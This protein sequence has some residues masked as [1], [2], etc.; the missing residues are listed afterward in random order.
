MKEATLP[1]QNSETPAS[2]AAAESRDALRRR[3][4][5]RNPSPQ[6]IVNAKRVLTVLAITDAAGKPVQGLLNRRNNEVDQF[7]V[8]FE[9]P[10]TKRSLNAARAAGEA[11]V[12]DAIDIRV[13]E[14]AVQ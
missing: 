7:F 6:V 3:I 2:A 4:L 11:V 14:E 5:G 10:E 13:G 9:R 12:D 8:G 1:E